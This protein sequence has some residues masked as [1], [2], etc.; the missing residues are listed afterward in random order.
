MHCFIINLRSQNSDIL[1]NSIL[2]VRVNYLEGYDA[3]PL[4]LKGMA[5]LPKQCRKKPIPFRYGFFVLG[6]G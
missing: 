2:P 1:A 6:K 5:G 3:R 4:F